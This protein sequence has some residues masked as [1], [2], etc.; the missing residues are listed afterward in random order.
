MWEYETM[1]SDDL[2][3]SNLLSKMRIFKIKDA[4]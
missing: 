3:Y 2:E 4:K 1:Y